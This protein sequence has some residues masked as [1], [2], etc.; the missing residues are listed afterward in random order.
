VLKNYFKIAFRNIF[1]NKIYSLINIIGLAVGM[2]CVLLISI[3]AIHEFSYDDFH[4]KSKQIYRVNYTLNRNNIKVA[5]SPP[6]LAEALVNNLPEVQTVTHISGWSKDY[7]VSYQNKKFIEKRIIYADQS[8]FDV[9]SFP[10]IA[11]NKNNSLAQP[12]Q[13][14]ITRSIAQKFFGIENPIGKFISID[15]PDNLFK[16]T[17]VVE[18]CPLNSHIQFDFIATRDLTVFGSWGSHCLFTYIVLPPYYSP[19]LLEAKFPDFIESNMA[20]Y[21]KKNYILNTP[22]FL[23]D[24]NLGFKIQLQ[25]LTDIHLDAEI[26]DQ[27]KNKGNKNL[28][29]T[30]LFVSLL[31][32]IISSINYINLSVARYSSRAK[33]IGLRKV[34]GADKKA[35]ISQFLLESILLVLISFLI[36]LIITKIAFSIFTDVTGTHISAGMFLNNTFLFSAIG[37]VLLLGIITG[38]Y[39][40]LFLTSFQPASILKKKIN[41]KNLFY[42]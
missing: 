38:I 32:I 29:Y 23:K 22:E 3:W 28:V 1:R 35:L 16:I 42:K 6:P 12:G 31:I 39:P 33:E 7:L 40:A 15:K 18:D 30:F 9:F 14:V 34:V 2:A 4:E 10:F 21:I 20:D 17:G 41:L 36:T 5:Y 24:E 19:N 8:F 37:F 27:A 13:V 11:G 26:I 25:A